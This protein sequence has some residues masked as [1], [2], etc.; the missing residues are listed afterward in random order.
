MDVI[1]KLFVFFNV[2]P[3]AFHAVWNIKETLKAAGYTELCEAD[4]RRVV[5]GGKYFVR[6]NDSSIIAPKLPQGSP[7]VRAF[8]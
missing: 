1:S 7:V 3:T 6:R 2:S 4:E 5:P 8:A